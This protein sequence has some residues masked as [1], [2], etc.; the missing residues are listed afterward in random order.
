MPD[1]DDGI[2]K[3]IPGNNISSVEWG[4]ILAEALDRDYD[5][6]KTK[7]TEDE[8]IQ[9]FI[10]GYKAF[11]MIETEITPEIIQMAKNDVKKFNR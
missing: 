5:E 9:M 7:Y 10:D 6:N 4:R 1:E 3:Q 8:M 11:M 2:F